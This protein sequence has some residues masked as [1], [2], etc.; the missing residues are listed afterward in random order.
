[1]GLKD[2]EQK[3]F[4]CQTLVLLFAPIILHKGPS[5]TTVP[6]QPWVGPLPLTL[7][8]LAVAAIQGDVSDIMNQPSLAMPHSHC[9]YPV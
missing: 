4:H 6:P 7:T 8:A 9:I 5:N 1:M 3:W 2:T